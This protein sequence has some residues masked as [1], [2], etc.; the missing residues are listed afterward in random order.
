MPTFALA[1]LFVLG[2]FSVGIVLFAHTILRAGPLGLGILTGSFSV[3]MTLGVLVVPYIPH[4]FRDSLSRLFALFVLS[5][6]ILALVGATHSLIVAA[7]IYGFSGLLAGPPATFYRTWLQIV[8]PPELLGR[9]TSIA[10]AISFGLE[11]SSAAMVG[12]ASRVV[13]AN[14]LILVAGGCATA[15]DVS[16][17]IRSRNAISTAM[18]VTSVDHPSE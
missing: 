10:R 15:V 1:N 12:V 14:V 5:D 17:V 4:T 16:G 11:P 3:G 6:G 18:P 2:I 9:V 7:I 8:P 13:T